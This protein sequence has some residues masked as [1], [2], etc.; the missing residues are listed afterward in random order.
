MPAFPRSVF[1]STATCSCD[2]PSS[3][4]IRQW[5][6]SLKHSQTDQRESEFACPVGKP[7]GSLRSGPHNDPQK[8]RAVIISAAAFPRRRHRELSAKSPKSPC[9]ND[10]SVP[11]DRRFG[12]T[13]LVARH[14]SRPLRI[15]TM[16]N[17]GS[18]AHVPAASK[19]RRVSNRARP[20]SQKR[21]PTNR[22][23]P[24]PPKKSLFT[25]ICG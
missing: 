21:T 3:L 19:R 24:A 4:G 22:E 2:A 7:V 12:S 9:L 23:K 1:P 16:A 18:D 6:H 5:I 10:A 8:H 15:D 11:V 14:P 17:F 20:S 25:R 13:H